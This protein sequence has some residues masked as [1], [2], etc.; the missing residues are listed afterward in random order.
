MA[1]KLFW[2]CESTTLDGTHDYSSADNT[3]TASGSPTIDA[4]AG[5]VGTNG[6]NSPGSALTSY[7]LDAAS[8]VGSIGSVGY[9]LKFVTAV[10][11]AGSSAGFQ[12]QGVSGTDIL[13]VYTDASLELAF[14]HQQDG[15]TAVNTPKTASA[16]L[17]ADTQ[18]GVIIRWDFSNVASVS[19]KIEVY[20][21]SGTLIDSAEVTATDY[22]TTAPTAQTTLRLGRHST[23]N[24]NAQY[25]DNFVIGDGYTD[26][27]AAM[28]AYTSYTQFASIPFF[29]YHSRLNPLLRM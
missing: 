10:P 5:M 27:T 25:S 12:L 24:T 17:S 26:V 14:R 18:Y 19:K 6:I 9:W 11:T 13:A 3:P 7:D 23:A 22:T 2:R 16:N 28:L 29:Q 15:G 8:I 21:S 1:I 4:T 20:D